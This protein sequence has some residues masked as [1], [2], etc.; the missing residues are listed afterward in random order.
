MA[1][2]GQDE[3]QQATAREHDRLQFC[4][5]VGRQQAPISH[6]DDAFDREARNDLLNH[7]IERAE[8]GGIA[9]E[10]LAIQ[11]QTVGGLHDAEHDL[12]H[13]EVRVHG[14]PDP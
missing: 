6:C 8:L 10:D 4:Q 9:V 1:W 7:G 13:N 14:V 2:H 5:V 12:A 3:F 11:R